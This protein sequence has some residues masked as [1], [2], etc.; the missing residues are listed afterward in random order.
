MDPMARRAIWDLL[1]RFRGRT[2]MLLCTHHL[3]E[4]E[5]LADRVVLLHAGRVVGR[6]T[7]LALKTQYAPFYRLAMTPRVAVAEVATLVP[8]AEEEWAT[9]T[10]CTVRLP[11]AQ[12][13]AFGRLFR[14]LE[15]KGVTLGMSAATLD[16]VF[17]RALGR[18]RASDQG[19]VNAAYE[20]KALQEAAELEELEQ[21]ELGLC[22]KADAPLLLS[23][24]P[25]QRWQ[26]RSLVH[27]RL[28]ELRRDCRATAALLLLP[29]AMLSIC[30]T[31]QFAT[32]HYL[33][34][35]QVNISQLG[36]LS[37]VPT[38]LNNVSEAAAPWSQQLA[39]GDFRVQPAG[40]DM[41]ALLRQ[42]PGYQYQG[43][44][45]FDPVLNGTVLW[46]NDHATSMLMAMVNWV[47]NAQLQ[48]V[49]ASRGLAVGSPAATIDGLA[50]VSNRVF[51]INDPVIGIFFIMAFA[52][53]SAAFVVLIVRERIS[54]VKH[55][56]M[57]AGVPPQVYWLA[58]FVV[59]FGCCLVLVALAMMLAHAEALDAVVGP[60]ALPLALVFIFFSAAMLPWTYVFSFL[61]DSPA[62]A[63]VMV[64]LVNALLGS[65]P[66]M[67]TYVLYITR[68][69]GPQLIAFYLR[70]IMMIFP[71]FSLGVALLDASRARLS[72]DGR[73][74][75]NLAIYGHVDAGDIKF[76]CLVCWDVLGRNIFTLVLH[77]VGWWLVLLLIE[78]PA[79]RRRLLCKSGPQVL[80]P[81]P[82]PANEDPDVK[83]ERLRVTSPRAAAE[84]LLARGLAKTYRRGNVPA[85]RRVDF[86]VGP[87]EC[88]GLLGVNGAGESE[89]KREAGCV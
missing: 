27:K 61:F 20:E 67:A 51:S 49:N 54:K 3:D 47:D 21:P 25:S 57:M 74:Y 18:K 10:E 24:Q 15:A 33:P 14:S 37:E 26:W 31:L 5:V 32:S 46:V 76:D 48:Q 80:P 75:A 29:I 62:S 22:D 30:R 78:K 69:D 85:V 84:V 23:Y 6:G 44:V 7:T 2:T 66:L 83:A 86:G 63:Y 56:M 64:L 42:A 39:W 40:T 50:M 71:Q 8:G 52:F 73:Y 60:A 11:A 58:N 36:C 45:E 70:W 65:V 77:A 82:V 79:W 12:Q 35:T 89:R 81:G 19:I 16:D 55:L 43:A 28:T 88:F 53:T 4:A 68:Q 9:E 38:V 17:V 41:A 59:D 87:G 34:A 1:L 72:Y 13:P